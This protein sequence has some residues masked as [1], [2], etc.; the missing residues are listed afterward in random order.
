MATNTARPGAGAQRLQ[1]AQDLHRNRAL[2]GNH[3][4]GGL[5]LGGRMS[6]CPGLEFTGTEYRRRKLAVALRTTSFRPNARQQLT[7][8]TA[9]LT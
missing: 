6:G 3:V 5:S 4:G 8:V 7:A 2:A 1:L 9:P